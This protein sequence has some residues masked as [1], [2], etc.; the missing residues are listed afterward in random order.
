MDFFLSIYLY[1]LKNL[2]LHGLDRHAHPEHK[3]LLDNIP[4]DHHNIL[5]NH[6]NSLLYDK[7]LPLVLSD[8]FP[9]HNTPRLHNEHLLPIYMF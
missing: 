3:N 6:K 9:N 1:Y 4:F 8:M 2:H 7:Q 5:V